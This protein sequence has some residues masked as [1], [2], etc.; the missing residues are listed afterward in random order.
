MAKSNCSRRSWQAPTDRLAVEPEYGFPCIARIGGGRQRRPAALRPLPP[1]AARYSRRTTSSSSAAEVAVAGLP[2]ERWGQ[3]VTAFVERA[4][5]IDEAALDEWCRNSALADYKR[6]RRWVF[7]AE[8]PKSPAG[9][10]LRRK[11]VTGEYE[12]EVLP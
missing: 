4:A 11:L 2:D 7:V 8:I 5:A 10:I 6:P 1:R 12:R 3:I 9:K